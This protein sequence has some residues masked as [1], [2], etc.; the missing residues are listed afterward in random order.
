[1][2][3]RPAVTAFDAVIANGLVVTLNPESDVIAGGA[4]WVRDG[5]IAEITVPA[6][7]AAPAA[8]VT[9]DARGGLVLPG[10]V[11]THTHLP[12]SLF[13]GLADDLPLAQWLNEHI[14]PVEAAHL[15]PR[16]VHA[17]TL[18]A[19]AE[20]LLGGTTTCCD[21]YFFEDAVAAAVEA[22]GL[23]AVLG[24]GVIDF[25]APGV[26]DP[27]GNITAAAGF[28]DRWDR[29]SPRVTPSIFC[30]SPC[31]CSRKTLCAAKAAADARGL[32]FQIHVAE[33]RSERDRFAAEKGCSPVAYLSRLGILDENTL[34]VHAVWVDDEDIGILRS[35]GARVSHVPQS[36][37]K[38][39]SGIAPVPEMI[40][41]G[42]PVGLGTDGCASN[43]DL[44]LFAEMDT[45]AKIHKV[46]K[47]DPSVMDAG[48]VLRMA[49]IEGARAIGLSD[50][51]GSIE[52]GKQADLIVVDT[53]VPRLT[54]L[55]RPESHLVYAAC[56]ADV[57]HVMVAGQLLVCDRRLTGLD[58][59]SIL[60]DARE[61]AEGIKGFR[62]KAEGF[63]DGERRADDSPI[64]NY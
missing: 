25:P 50:R 51:I 55:Y 41:A 59:E 8:A 44:D 32:L 38:L 56:G 9:V 1:M 35:T 39:A 21:G 7:E 6:P 49:T 12:M 34:A 31:T 52:V 64:C 11:N 62:L 61:I 33:T 42:I 47:M 30:H 60:R 14:F 15:N 5:R 43:N 22:A 54:P 63:D 45:A 20:L 2:R 16:T 57:R 19:C 53:A 4:V 36:N 46:R 13:R 27:S 24:Q 48:M 17:G 58:L 23:R 18:L 3:R 40:A 37:M 10:L 26:P 28:A 29:R